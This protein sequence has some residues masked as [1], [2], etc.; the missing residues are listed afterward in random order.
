VHRYFL[1][2]LDG[3][4]LAALEASLGRVADPLAPGDRPMHEGCAPD[5]A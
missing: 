4:E 5:E 2:R 1:D 3:G